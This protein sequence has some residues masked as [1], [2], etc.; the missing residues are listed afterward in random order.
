LV[1]D[2]DTTVNSSPTDISGKGNHGAFKG[3]AQ[4]SPADKAFKFDGNSDYI[5]TAPLGFSGD[6]VHSV[7][8][9]FWS[10]VE[11]STFGLTEH[12]LWGTGG[13]SNSAETGFSM[14]NTFV[15]V[16]R[17]A[18]ATKYPMTFN[19][20]QWNHIC[21]AYSSGGSVN[22]RLWLNGVELAQD[23]SVTSTGAYSFQ[24]SEYLVLGTWINNTTPDTSYP[25]DG[26]IS[27]FKLYNVA[28]EPSEVKKLYNLGRTGR[29][30]VI[31]DTAVGIGK[32]P[33]AQLDVRGNLRVSGHAFPETMAPR[34]YTSIKTGRFTSAS[35]PILTGFD[36]VG[37]GHSEPMGWEVH[38]NFNIT[39]TS[40]IEVYMD[41]FYTSES[42][43]TLRSIVEHGTRR[44][45]QDN[46]GTTWYHDK[47]YLGSYIA[48]N[49][50]PLYSVIRIIN[51]HGQHSSIHGYNSSTMRYH[52]W[53][54]TVYVHPGVGTTI[55]Y[56]QGNL[57]AG[58]A[59]QR[60][61]GIRLKPQSGGLTGAYTIFAIK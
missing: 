30:M 20:N 51:P 14:Y 13:V 55:D 44:Q 27:N 54:E 57:R 47:F 42:P 6:Q 4:Y 52:A 36:N 15:Q 26:K 41:G 39:A 10:D 43:T 33:E 2:F 7:S 5:Q 11:Q 24:A 53:G 45:R 38:I 35:N 60:L 49:H 21:M 9:W 31:S 50:N 25:W 46:A 16:W 18:G 37:D 23:S 19:A 40:D 61:H 34:Y 48:I 29:S 59:N 8:L 28:L 3:T 12:A 1:L 32:V 56:A 17:A 58:A 22:S